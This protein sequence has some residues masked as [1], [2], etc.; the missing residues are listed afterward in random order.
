MVKPWKQFRERITTLY[1]KE[2]RTLSEVQRIMKDQHGFVASFVPSSFSFL[3][4]SP[5]SSIVS[6][7][8]R[9]A[10]ASTTGT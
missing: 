8:A 1:I 5:C 4:L 7:S 3:L 9:T 2:A 6:A 10:S